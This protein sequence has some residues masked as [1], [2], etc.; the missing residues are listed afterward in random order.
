MRSSRTTGSSPSGSPRSPPGSTRRG[1][2][3][4]STT[5]WLDL[6]GL[7]SS[8]V[9]SVGST[10]PRKNPR[11][12]VEAYRRARALDGDVPPLVLTGPPP[13]PDLMAAVSS[14]GGQAVGFVPDANL[15]G[16]V[17]RAACV[18]LPSMYEG[19]GLPIVEAMAAGTPVVA[20][21][22]PA[23]REASGGLATL[24][25]LAGTATGLEGDGPVDD[26]TADAF[27]SAIVETVR[28]RISGSRRTAG[29]GRAVHV[30][31]HGR[32][33]ACRLRPRRLRNRWTRF[34]DRQRRGR[35]A[36]RCAAGPSSRGRRT[37]TAARTCRRRPTASFGCSG[38]PPRTLT[39][40]E[41]ADTPRE[42]DQL[43]TGDVGRRTAQDHQEAV[44]LVEVVEPG[45]PLVRRRRMPVGDPR[46]GHVPDPPAGPAEP[47]RRVG[48]LVVEEE[49]GREPADVPDGGRPQHRRRRRRTPRRPRG[50]PTARRQDRQVPGRSRTGRAGA[51]HRRC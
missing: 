44:A 47:Q 28:A 38:R 12:L 22:I 34:D 11:L 46:L 4:T 43:V 33:D 32:R 20:S 16:V 39:P 19:F 35:R 7:P 27:A 21:D 15:R 31:A 37:R 30:G 29:L 42:S 18:V 8:Y 48:V 51:R 36:G 49:V 14:M 25:P 9:L 17:A 1:P 45:G 10:G 6:Q 13:A 50:C 2:P 5:P 23:H 26:T 24:V 40:G 41:A 3:A